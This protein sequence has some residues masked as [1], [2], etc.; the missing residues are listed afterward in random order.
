MTL[1]NIG[2][3]MLSKE[4]IFYQILNKL[5]SVFQGSAVVDPDLELVHPDLIIIT[6]TML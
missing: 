4:I 3:S 6:L 2:I 1:M 5:T